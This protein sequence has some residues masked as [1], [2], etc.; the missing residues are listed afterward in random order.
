MSARDL[1]DSE[2]GYLTPKRD[3][4]YV[5]YLGWLGLVLFDGF[6]WVKLCKFAVVVTIG[7]KAKTKKKTKER[8]KAGVRWLRWL[9]EE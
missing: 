1:Y 2:P 8:H 3:D 5:L 7:Q 9:G 6:E 4:F